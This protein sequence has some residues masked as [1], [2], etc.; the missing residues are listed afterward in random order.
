M[1]ISPVANDLIQAIDNYIEESGKTIYRFSF[2]EQIE[3]QRK[4]KIL[5]N[6]IN[7]LIAF[8]TSRRADNKSGK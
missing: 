5:D 3:L 8:E 6:H 1:E 2:E 7:I 4:I